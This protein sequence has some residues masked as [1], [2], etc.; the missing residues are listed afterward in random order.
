MDQQNRDT[1]EPD[2][3]IA[4]H[5]N[6]RIGEQEKK[7]QT[8]SRKTGGS[9]GHVDWLEFESSVKELSQRSHWVLSLIETHLF[10]KPFF[11]GVDDE[12]KSKLRHC[13]L[14][15]RLNMLLHLV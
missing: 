15:L 6:K 3:S 7:A 13:M 11:L 2:C 5:R 10:D 4:Q 9:Q 12:K 14:L 8:H 1:L